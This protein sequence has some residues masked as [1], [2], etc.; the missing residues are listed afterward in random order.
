MKITIFTNNQPRHLSLVETLSAVSDDIH[1]IHE[2]NTL[3]TGVVADFIRKSDVMQ[4]YWEKVTSAEA[5]VFGRPRFLSQKTMPVLYGD[6]SHMT[7]EMLGEAA[8]ADVFVVFGA[9]FIK[10]PMCDFLVSRKAINIH[11]GVAPAYRG[12]SCNFWAM[13]DGRPD[14]VGATVHRLSKGLDQGAV[15][16]HCFPETAPDAG[17]ELGMRAVRSAHQGLAER[18]ADGSF[19]EIE[20]VPQDISQ[21]LR[22]SRGIEF[23]DEI[24]AEFLD[25]AYNKATVQ[26]ALDTR[27]LTAFRHPFVGG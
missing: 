15:L 6:V 23:T 13:Y 19:M 3:F 5:A 4:R 17:F 16:F 10:G 9:S 26:T 25:R 24:A 8:E 11:M 14:L 12:H 27:D 18:I 20:P 21:Q 2:C 1:V 7:P 22:Y